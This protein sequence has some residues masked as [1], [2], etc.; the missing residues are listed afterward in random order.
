MKKIFSREK[1]NFALYG[2]LFGTLFPI[3]GTILQIKLEFSTITLVNFIHVQKEFPLLWIIDMAPFWLSLFAMFGGIQ[4]DRINGYNKYLLHEVE[5]K[6]LELKEEHEREKML[7][8]EKADAFLEM[9]D[10]KMK[11]AEI[12]KEL[13]H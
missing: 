7:I 2:F 9:E 13:V 11:L 5:E 10:S 12:E 1:L 8:I 3:F 6:D 4:L